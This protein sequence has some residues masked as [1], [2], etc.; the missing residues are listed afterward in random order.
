M[1]GEE[2]NEIVMT[3]VE[4]AMAMAP[5]VRERYLRGVCD[6]DSALLDEV[7]TRVQWEERMGGFLKKPM[8]PPRN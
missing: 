1:A 3:L 7:W 8:L 5:E 6:A 2:Y 4:R